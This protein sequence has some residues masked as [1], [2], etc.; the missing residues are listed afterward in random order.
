MVPRNV[1]LWHA[2]GT[3]CPFPGPAPIHSLDS[4]IS[5]TLQGPDH[6]Q[7]F[8]SPPLSTSYKW[9]P[10]PLNSSSK[11]RIWGLGKKG[12][13]TS[14]WSSIYKALGWG[15]HMLLLKDNLTLLPHFL[16]QE[17]GVY[18]DTGEKTSHREMPWLA[19]GHLTREHQSANYRQTSEILWVWF[20]TTAINW[21]SQQSEPHNFFWFPSAYKNYIYTIL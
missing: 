10:P 21:I 20:E 15:V 17:A 8:W 6:P 14:E 7:T 5:L 19:Q 13:S 3:V 1:P 4:P 16:L 11:S 2:V 18:H 9:S 12:D